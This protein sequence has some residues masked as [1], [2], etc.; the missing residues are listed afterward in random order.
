MTK[1]WNGNVHLGNGELQNLRSH[2][3]ERNRI[4]KYAPQTADHHALQQGVTSVM[5]SVEDDIEFLQERL[6]KADKNSARR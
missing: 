6:E 1:E 5:D 2:N 4:F 3:E